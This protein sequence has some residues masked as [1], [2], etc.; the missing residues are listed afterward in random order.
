MADNITLYIDTSKD[1][2]TTFLSRQGEVLGKRSWEND[3]Y[4]GRNL[5]VAL[6]ELLRET[7]LSLTNISEIRVHSGPGGYS[8]LRAGIM[9]A[10]TLGV[11]IGIP[12][13]KVSGENWT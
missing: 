8:S 13:K 2:A 4:T 11:T 1:E 10:Q 3:R 9:T 12:V 5:L 7:K 6:E